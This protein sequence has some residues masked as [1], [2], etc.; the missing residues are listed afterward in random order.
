MIS[1]RFFDLFEDDRLARGRAEAGR[2]REDE[3]G[4]ILPVL[5]MPCEVDDPLVVL[6]EADR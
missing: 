2:K 4:A 3:T 5:A 6:V 1:R